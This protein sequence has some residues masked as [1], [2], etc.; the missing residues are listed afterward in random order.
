MITGKVTVLLE[1]EEC[2]N[3]FHIYINVKLLEYQSIE[4]VLNRYYTHQTYICN[5]CIKDAAGAECD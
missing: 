5:N 3:L 1:C 4:S 2:G